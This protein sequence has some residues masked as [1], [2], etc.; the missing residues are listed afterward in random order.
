MN[1]EIERSLWLEL[2]PQ[3]LVLFPLILVGFALTLPRDAAMYLG[4]FGF[5][6]VGILWGIRM[7]FS[8]ILREVNDHTWDW[9]RMSALSPWSMAWGKLIGST[10][11]PWYGGAICLAIFAFAGL[12]GSPISMGQIILFLVGLAFAFHAFAMMIS[13]QFIRQQGTGRKGAGRWI[14]VALSLFFFFLFVVPATFALTQALLH[15]FKKGNTLELNVYWYHINIGK[16]LIEFTLIS[17][18]VFVGWSLLGL[19]RS[20]RIQQQYTNRPWVWLFFVVFLLSYVAGFATNWERYVF[21]NPLMLPEF[22]SAWKQALF[23]KL[24]TC[25][26][27]GIGLTYLT[28]LIE[29][30]D[31]VGFRK[32]A[33]AAR[34]ARWGDV[35]SHIPAW[36]LNLVLLLVL[37]VGT[38]WSAPAILRLTPKGFDIN[39]TIALSIVFFFILRD[40][41]LILWTSLS[42]SDKGSD[43]ISIVYLFVLYILL[44]ALLNAAKAYELSFYLMPINPKILQN[45]DPPNFRFVLVSAVIQSGI[46]LFLCIQ[47]WQRHFARAKDAA[48]PKG[49]G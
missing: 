45:T 37:V 42:P 25:L 8:S 46:V 2:S 49:D 41:A 29:P 44:P 35:F 31:P 40:I 7:A 23:P 47:R 22:G 27:L 30:K 48:P 10:L 21:A 18:Y 1:P 26:P 14:A 39:L 36:M 33:L 20:M 13:L 3:R 38:W 32:L 16:Y 19:Y 24:I 6:A 28:M 11:A 34:E 43:L 17:L 9:Q 4:L 15:F 5:L 12:R